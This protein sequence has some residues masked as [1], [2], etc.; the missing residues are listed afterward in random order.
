MMQIVGLI[1]NQSAAGG[2]GLIQW[3]HPVILTCH[4]DLLEE[5][6]RNITIIQ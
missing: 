2:T 5:N 1:K 4:H 3:L 6:I